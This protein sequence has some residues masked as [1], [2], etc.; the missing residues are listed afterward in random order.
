MTS[1]AQ[2]LAAQSTKIV[3]AETASKIIARCLQLIIATSMMIRTTPQT[4]AVQN[5]TQKRC[6]RRHKRQQL[7][8]RSKNAE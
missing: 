8:G 3:V 1:H 6:A 4:A 5:N 2:Q 7:L